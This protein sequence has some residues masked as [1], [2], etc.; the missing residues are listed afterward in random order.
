MGKGT[1]YGKTIFFGEHFTVYGTPVIKR[2]MKSIEAFELNEIGELMNQ[3][4]F[5]LKEAELSCPELDLLVDLA[6]REGAV[7]A[8]QT[9]SGGGGCMLALTP[10]KALQERVASTIEG[11][12]FQA[13]RTV[14]G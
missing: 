2:A 14:V 8:K 3:N 13:I 4:H 6:R 11:K 1:G 7:G 10:G 9:G 12:G 5:L